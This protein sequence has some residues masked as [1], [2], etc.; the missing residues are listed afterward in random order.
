MAHQHLQLQANLHTQVP[1]TDKLVHPPNQTHRAVTLH[2]Q[3]LRVEILV[4]AVQ[5]VHTQVHPSQV[6]HR[7]HTLEPQVANQVPTHTLDLPNQ[8][9][10]HLTQENELTF[11]SQR[12]SLFQI[13]D[14]FQNC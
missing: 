7:A 13:N 9:T 1:T 11:T 10:C 2:L 14:P 12:G 4:Q 3:E 8:M 5:E 6:H